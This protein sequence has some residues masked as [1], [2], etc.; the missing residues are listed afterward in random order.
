MHA[1]NF[2]RIL[3]ISL[4]QG[5]QFLQPNFFSVCRGRFKIYNDP[6]HGEM[7]GV[8]AYPPSRVRRKVYEFSKHMPAILGFELLPRGDLWPNLFQNYCLDRR[9]I[10]LYFFPSFIER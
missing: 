9:D 6:E 8:Q 5:S 3:V 7:N 2:P 1:L 4:Y 10:G